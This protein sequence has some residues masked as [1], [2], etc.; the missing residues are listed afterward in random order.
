MPEYYSQIAVIWN[1]IEKDRYRC[2]TDKQSGKALLKII[3]F[4]VM[5]AGAHTSTDGQRGNHNASSF[6]RKWSSAIKC[7]ITVHSFWLR[8]W[9]IKTWQK[10][11]LEFLQV[12]SPLY[13]QCHDLSPRQSTSSVGSPLSWNPRGAAEPMADIETEVLFLTLQPS[14]AT[15]RICSRCFDCAGGI[16]HSGWYLML[17]RKVS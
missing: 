9:C 4:L 12:T 2:K 5:W 14:W 7:C 13:S 6:P 15:S 8:E 10:M 17:G 3:L 11:I 1:R 16:Y